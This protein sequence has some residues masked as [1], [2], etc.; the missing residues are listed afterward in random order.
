[1]IARQANQVKAGRRQVLAESGCTETSAG[2]QGDDEGGRGLTH[3][4][5]HN[6]AGDRADKDRHNEQ[7]H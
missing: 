6:D 2:N 7:G 3:R 4:S 5:H 1:G